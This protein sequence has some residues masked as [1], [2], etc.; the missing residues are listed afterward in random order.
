MSAKTNFDVLTVGTATRDVFLTSDLFKV[1]KDTAHL[2]TLGFEDGRAECFAFGGKIDVDAPTFTTGGGATNAAVTFARA[3]LATGSIFSIGADRAGEDV[4][5]ELSKENVRCFQ[6]ID[7]KLSTGYSTLLLGRDG[8]R[9]ALVNRGASS[10]INLRNVPLARLSTKL[11]HVSPGELPLATATRIVNHFQKQGAAIVINPSSH[12]IKMGLRDLSPI[13]KKT[14]VLTLNRSEAAALAKVDGKDERKI[15]AKLCSFV[16][17]FVVITDGPDGV[18]VSNGKAIYRA[19]VF[20]EKQ[21]VDRT[22]AGDAFA[23]GFSAYLF[24]HGGVAEPSEALLK[25]AIRFASA[26][27]TSVVEH[28]GAKTGIL[29]M[30][31]FNRSARFKNLT[32]RKTII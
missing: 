24:A 23:S 11:L 14:A 21:I 20:K 7:S 32:V 29:S 2:K 22:G 9:T 28:I 12:Y 18:L 26:N 5:E 17:G 31:S 4:V 8:E 30:Q 19:G 15:F 27:A 13:L 1:V 16:P 25:D 10:N 3:G 6:S